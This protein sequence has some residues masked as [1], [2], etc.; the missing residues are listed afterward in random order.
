M[1]IQ[2][3]EVKFWQFVSAAVIIAALVGGTLVRLGYVE[4]ALNDVDK[5][6]LRVEVQ[7]ELKSRSIRGKLE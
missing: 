4:S 6:L 7:L 3:M 1:Q 2:F 5:R